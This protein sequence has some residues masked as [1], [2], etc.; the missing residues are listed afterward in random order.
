MVKTLETEIP[1]SNQAMLDLEEQK[2]NL[3]CLR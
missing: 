3:Y 1:K 2:N